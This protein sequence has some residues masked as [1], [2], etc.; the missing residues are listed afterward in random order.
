MT[1]IY[2]EDGHA[3]K[4]GGVYYIMRCAGLGTIEPYAVQN[5]EKER[6]CMFFSGV[7]LNG[8]VYVPIVGR[9]AKGCY[10][11]REVLND[12]VGVAIREQWSGGV[13]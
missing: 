12:A 5:P 11:S 8:S 4:K 1:D 7:G 9:V 2:T 10:Q 3:I 6:A 13:E